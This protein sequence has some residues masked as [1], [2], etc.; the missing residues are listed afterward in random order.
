MVH[1][2]DDIGVDD[3]FSSSNDAEA[4][5]A[6][7]SRPTYAAAGTTG[8]GGDG[9]RAP[10]MEG[11]RVSGRDDCLCSVLCS[12]F[13]VLLSPLSVDSGIIRH[14]VYFS[15]GG[16]DRGQGVTLRGDNDDE[17]GTGRTEVKTPSVA[18]DPSQFSL[19]PSFCC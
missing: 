18:V 15:A 11:S 16:G 12:L 13:P 3:A 8:R 19:F 5:S 1:H 9:E 14:L 7:F 10:L 4:L 2:L 17:R 6:A